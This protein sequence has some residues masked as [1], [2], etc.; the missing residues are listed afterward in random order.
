MAFKIA[1][2]KIVKLAK[3]VAALGEDDYMHF[4]T[5]VSFIKT[6]PTTAKFASKP[7]KRKYT[8]KAKPVVVAQGMLLP[9]RKKSSSEVDH[10]SRSVAD[11]EA[12]QR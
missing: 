4:K 11:Q 7:A 5:W 3:A 8:R 2:N 9:K 1:A 6:L 12:G 10:S